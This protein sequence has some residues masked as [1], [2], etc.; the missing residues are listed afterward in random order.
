MS[1]RARPVRTTFYVEG[2]F[3]WLLGD[4]T[5]K[6]ADSSGIARYTMERDE[7]SLR[8]GAGFRFSWVGGLAAD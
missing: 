1:R 3:L 2:S 7:T 8:G 5:E 4:R 6:L